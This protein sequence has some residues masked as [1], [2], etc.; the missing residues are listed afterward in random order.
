MHTSPSRDGRL[1]GQLLLWVFW[2]LSVA[3]VASE[4]VVSDPDLWGH[5]LYGL[6]HLRTGQLT[7]TDAYSYTASGAAWINHEWLSELSFGVAWDNLGA[8]GLWGIRLL[9]VAAVLA[10]V[11]RLIRRTTDGLWAGLLVYVVAWYQMTRGF[12]IRPQLFTYAGFALLLWLVHEMNGAN[13]KTGGL[14]A[15]AP[16]LFVPLLAVWANLHGGFLV[17]FA[18]VLLYLAYR[19]VRFGRERVGR[20]RSGSGPGD[21]PRAETALG[22]RRWGDGRRMAILTISV[23]GA[24]LATLLNPYGVG[25]WRWLGDSLSAP[26]GAVI[27]EWAPVFSVTPQ[28]EVLGLYLLA[29]LAVLALIFTR[30][31]RG[32]FEF[33]LLGFLALAAMRSN[34]HG[35]FFAIAAAIYL[36]KHLETFI[37][38][39]ARPRR[40]SRQFVAA[41]AVICGAYAVGVHTREGHR[42]DTILVESRRHPLDAY[43][44]L[45]SRSLAGNLAVHFDW[46]QSALWYLH[47]INRVAFDGRFRTVYPQAAEGAFLRF[48]AAAEGWE[49]LLDEYDTDLVL[50][51]RGWAEFAKMEAR[52]DWIRAFER[53]GDAA[54]RGE[55]SSAE[56]GLS[57]GRQ[58][59]SEGRADDP[60]LFVRS[61][62]YPDL[63]VELGAGPVA[64]QTPPATFVFG[65]GMD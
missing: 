25:L 61:G 32:G 15:W 9:L 18:T 36:P 65:A 2:L 6:E 8:V 16:L 17:G 33:A 10:I 52:D 44:F 42:P 57:G 31:T 13:G 30:R 28:T 45:E 63:E 41:L 46:A 50:M 37:P 43:R 20:Q 24:G 62:R 11:V 7:R 38:W 58:A 54:G 27:T 53:G 60:V 59:G 39:L 3:R 47:R 19:V 34:R 64:G 21:G 48:H 40:F 51:P 29:A 4:M 5:V 55:S 14:S 1:D 35:V 49:G 26:R 23:L 22:E 12:A 56:P